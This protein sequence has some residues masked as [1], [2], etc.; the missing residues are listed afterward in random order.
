M[1]RRRVHAAVGVLL[2]G[3]VLVL[4]GFGV[5]QVAEPG[6][7]LD[8]AKAEL[9]AQ[10]ERVLAAVPEQSVEQVSRNNGL[11]PLLR[12]CD[13]GSFKWPGGMDVWLTADADPEA[14][15]ASIAES[16]RADPEWV[17]DTEGVVS[18]SPYAVNLSDGGRFG[19]DDVV[20][21]G[22]AVLEPSDGGRLLLVS[23]FS[24]CFELADFDP[25]E[26]Y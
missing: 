11:A 26:K 9:I 19:D 7:T 24:R 21:I 6:L 23:G 25:F 12:S 15:I 14:V 8:E 22:V 4:T 2:A 3:L 10:Q 17:V 20:S 16:F 13:E 18:P 1:R 5:T